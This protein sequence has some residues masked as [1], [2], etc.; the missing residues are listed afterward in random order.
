MSDMMS[1]IGTFLGSQGGKTAETGAAA[2]GGLL[3]NWMANREAQK[4]QQF[5]ENLITNPAKFN[6]FVSG[7]EK[8]LTAGLTA[9]VA[10][11]TDAYGAER[12][13]GSS[14]MAMQSMYAQALAPVEQAQQN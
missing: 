9:D 1:Q 2:G 10:R 4:K 14:P 6:S 13:L 12:G 7:F 11:S 3:Q 5:V 8:P